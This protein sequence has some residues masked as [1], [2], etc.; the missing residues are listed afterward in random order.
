MLYATR[1]YNEC[2]KYTNFLSMGIDKLNAFHKGLNYK[3]V[4]SSLLEKYK[5]LEVVAIRLEEKGAY[6]KTRKKEAKAPVFKVR[7]VDTTGAGDAWTAGF[8]V[9]YFLEGMDLKESI[10]FANAVAAIKCTKYGAITS[11][12]YRKEV[13]EFIKKLDNL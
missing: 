13:M 2:L 7:V 8:I 3:H 5:K 9:S 1:M 11:L 10:T 4:V 12:P 6:V